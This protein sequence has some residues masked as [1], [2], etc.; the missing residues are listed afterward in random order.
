MGHETCEGRAEMG[1]GTP[2]EHPRWGHRWSS[3]GGAKRVS[4]V[5]KW[6]EGRHVNTPAGPMGG[7][8]WG[9][10]K[11]ARGVPKWAG[12]RHVNTPSGAI[13]GAPWGARNVRRVCQKMGGGT[14]C[15]R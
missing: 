14:P 11:R 10:T 2:C 7:A 3:L 9:G 5:P 4:G 13:G 6:A 15:A 8:P 12:G 1:G